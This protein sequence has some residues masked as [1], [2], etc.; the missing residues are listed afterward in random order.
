MYI[1][2]ALTG[3]FLALAAAYFFSVLTALQYLPGRNLGVSI[4]GSLFTVFVF[5]PLF[6]L[7]Y[8]FWFVIPIGAIIGVLIPKIAR[9]YPRRTTVFYGLLLGVAVGITGSLALGFY[10]GTPQNGY[11]RDFFGVL[12]MSLYSA[13]WTGF[14]SFL[15]GKSAVKLS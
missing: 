11:W 3:I 8:S 2:E 14:Y 10:I 6:G 1:K 13:V 7:L 5:Y 9:D 15:C 12:V 4:A